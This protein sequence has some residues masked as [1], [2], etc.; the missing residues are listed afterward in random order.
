MKLS[1]SQQELSLRLH[2]RHGWVHLRTLIAVRWIGIA[3]QL[4][5]VA[6]TVLLLH[7]PLPL[8][9][10]FVTIMASA[11]L[12]VWAIRRLRRGPTINDRVAA[13]YLVFDAAQLAALLFL[14]GGLGNPFAMLLIVPLTVGAAILRRGL[15]IMLAWVTVVLASVLI[16]APDTLPWGGTALPVIFHFGLWLALVFSAMFT[17]LYVYSVAAGV[18]QLSGAFQEMQLALG[19]TQ[20]LAAVGALAAAAA[21]E[22][23]T[24]LSTIAVV[25]KELARD[26]PA[27]TPQAEDAAL[28]LSQVERCR[29]ILADLAQ[30]PDRSGEAAT[31]FERLDVQTLLAMVVEPYRKAEV[32]VVFE[33]DE[34]NQ[35]DEPQ[36]QPLPELLHGLGNIIQNAMQFARSQVVFHLCWRPD[37]LRIEVRD[38]GAGMSPA[39]LERIGEPYIST[40]TGQA[41]HM[42]LGIFIAVNLLEKM[43]AQLTYGNLSQG[44]TVAIVTWPAAR[45]LRIVSPLENPKKSSIAAP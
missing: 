5:A 41:G 4:G 10:I 15:V 43:G 32:A 11:L 17:A 9:Q 27:D 38:D 30:R 14:T 36:L 20:Q 12:N 26:L 13:A 24:P 45:D 23:G 6:A 29:K 21:H 28:L 44:G 8:M 18:A 19:R 7:F 33:L 34:S 22:L 25:A 2:N 3:G 31:G 39:L 40:R 1:K 35:G 37:Y 42:G 16:F